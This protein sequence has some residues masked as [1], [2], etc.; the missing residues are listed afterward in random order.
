MREE[1][2]GSAESF[3]ILHLSISLI[4][5]GSVLIN[6]RTFSFCNNLTSIDA[7]I[8]KKERKTDVS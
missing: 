6:K 4:D 8:K 1:V 7:N 3:L 2:K 5:L